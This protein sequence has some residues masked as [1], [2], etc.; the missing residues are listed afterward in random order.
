[1]SDK[2]IKQQIYDLI[3][4]TAEESDKQALRF[5]DNKELSYRYAAKGR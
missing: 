2:S 3:E 1:M 4:N 5:R